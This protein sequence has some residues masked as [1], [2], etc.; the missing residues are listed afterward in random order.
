M[1]YL[2]LVCAVLMQVCL[3]A[4]YSW[5]VYVQPLKAL[6]GLA[7]GP[8]QIPFTMFYFAFPLTMMIAGQ[9]LPRVGPRRSA[10]AGGLLFGGGWLL[11]GL[12]SHSFIL[13]V[14]GIGLLAGVGAGMAYIVPI[15]VCI[16]WFPK[17]KGLVT[18]IAVAGFG[19]GAA[20]VSQAGGYMI[21]TMGFSPFNTFFVFG[22]LFLCTVVAAGAM[23]RFPK[24]DAA[25]GTG[26][27]LAPRQVLGHLNFR[28]LY[29]AM[30]IGLAAGF[31]VNANLKEL[32]QGGPDAVGLGITAVSLFALANAAGRVIWGAV[33]DR[34]EAATAIQAN[35]MFQAAVLGLAPLLLKT[36][37][38]FLIVALVTG[39]NYGGVLVIYVSS[40]SRSWGAG[41]IGQVYGWLFT[42]NIPASLSPIL[43]GF[44]FDRFHHFT[45]A[46]ISLAGLLAGCA[47][48]IRRR[49]GVVNDRECLGPV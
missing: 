39:F 25:A 16:R 42:S 21:N 2:I 24:T 11:A 38:G 27:R 32:Y 37:F 22:T 34:I 18:G 46:L 49:S 10:M 3:G 6:T 8:V 29:F 47:L 35:L 40:A 14:L 28:I 13:T 48:M 44:V 12:G 4:T 36:S 1:R 19:G 23:M 33:F 45:P 30:F 41:N 5:S 26:T 20:M 31:A 7:Q 9:F 15:A 17:S 43:A